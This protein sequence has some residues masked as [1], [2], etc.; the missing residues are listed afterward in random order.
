MLWREIKSEK[1]VLGGGRAMEI[2]RMVRKTPQRQRTFQR[3]HD[4]GER[5]RGRLGGQRQGPEVG[6]GLGPVRYNIRTAE[7]AEGRGWE[8][9]GAGLTGYRPER[10]WSTHHTPSTRPRRP[11][12]PQDLPGP[13][14]QTGPSHS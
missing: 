13:A 8:G 11:A 10:T 12:A 2:N 6:A 14:P 7:G 5:A 1:G 4:V 3:R 9:R